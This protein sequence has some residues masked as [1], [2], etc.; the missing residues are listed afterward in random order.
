MLIELFNGNV[1][2]VDPRLA[3]LSRIDNIYLR[4]RQN[5][6]YQRRQPTVNGRQAANQ[7]IQSAWKVRRQIQLVDQESTKRR[8]RSFISQQ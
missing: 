6:D 1:K 5:S 8:K 4:F 3:E 7:P 2:T